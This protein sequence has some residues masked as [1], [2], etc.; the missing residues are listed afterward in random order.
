MNILI[1]TPDAVGSTLLQRL[2]TTYCQF[3]NF[4][5][6]YINIHEL[7]NGISKFYS[8][9][10]NRE[11]LRSDSNLEYSQ[12]LSEII[13]ILE[14]TDHEI[15]GRMAQYHLLR[16][17]DPKPDLAQLY[18][19][20]N[21][22]FFII[23]TRRTNVF[24]HSLSQYINRVSKHLNVY[25]PN[26]KINVFADL[27]QSPIHV[28]QL[29]LEHTLN[30][31]KNYVQWSEEFFNIGSYFDYTKD[32]AN[33][34]QYILNL[35]LFANSPAQ[36]WKTTFGIDF[37]KWN[38]CHLLT[39]D[40]DNVPNISALT[41]QST[42]PNNDLLLLEQYY[43]DDIV[44]SYNNVADP[45]WPNV[46][47]IQDYANLPKH[48]IDECCNVHKLNGLTEYRRNLSLIQQLPQEDQNFLIQNQKTYVD[49][50]NTVK[51]MVE[52]GIMPGSI[53]IKKQTLS[54][55][56]RLIKNFNE[57]LDTYNEWATNN[58]DICQPMQNGELELIMVDE[59]TQWRSPM[60]GYLSDNESAHLI[61]YT[62]RS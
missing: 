18:K 14:T 45:S 29:A 10:F 7:T 32:V 37:K 13:K 61:D 8:H 33:I 60:V 55:K 39:S 26:Q 6:T 58:S 28:D 9:D 49:G 22:N 27:Y 51:K 44:K 31:Y 17:Q 36:D 20:C 48:I 46:K 35:P 3:Q 25:S 21:E 4:S 5:E 19:F 54:G 34:E 57:C 38:L 24:E 43:K 53:P 59:K 50:I 52:L 62:H 56:T 47:N 2:I 11:I 15:I 41:N 30:Q 42:G 1:L 12:S 16:R 23:A 40:L